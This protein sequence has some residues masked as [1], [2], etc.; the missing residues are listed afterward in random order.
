MVAPIFNKI[1]IMNEGFT[2]ST[3][4]FIFVFTDWVSDVELRYQLGFVM[5]AIVILILTIN[6]II[7]VIEMIR[8]IIKQFKKSRWEKKWRK[9]IKEKEVCVNMII[10]DI[11]KDYSDL[12]DVMI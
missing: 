2:L 3:T 5:L 8:E 11:Y 1:V 6:L 10:E 7:I 12:D 4:Y 9:Y